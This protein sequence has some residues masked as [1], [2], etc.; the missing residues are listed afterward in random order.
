M[1][2]GTLVHLGTNMWR[3]IDNFKGAGKKHMK[4]PVHLP[5]VLTRNYGMNT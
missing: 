4:M 2:W 5:C 1:L 3:D